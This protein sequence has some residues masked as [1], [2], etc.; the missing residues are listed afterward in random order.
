[1]NTAIILTTSQA[2][3]VDNSTGYLVGAFIA[4]VVFV[5]LVYTLVKPEKF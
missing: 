3:E 5:Y 4:L 2:L 1:M